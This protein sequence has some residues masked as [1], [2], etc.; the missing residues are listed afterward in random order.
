MTPINPN[1]IEYLHMSINVFKFYIIYLFYYFYYIKM[2]DIIDVIK[3]IGDSNVK[4]HKVG[5]DVCIVT[6]RNISDKKLKIIKKLLKP[7]KIV[8][9]NKPKKITD[10]D[11]KAMLD[12]LEIANKG[13]AEP[14]EDPKK[15]ETVEL[16]IKKKKRVQSKKNKMWMDF[17]SE[18][19]KQAGLEGKSRSIIMQEASKHYKK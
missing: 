6:T 18:Y 4:A 11:I 9:E 17:V 10:D 16:D 1:I 13:G 5:S 14:E 15:I 19:A 12:K 3:E 8:K 2:A 7:K